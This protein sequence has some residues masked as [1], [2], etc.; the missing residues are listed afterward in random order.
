MSR[1]GLLLVV[2]LALSACNY[3]H[4][5]DASAGASGR[6]GGVSSM[7][8]VSLNYRTMQAAVLGPQCLRCHSAAGGNQGGLS[9]ET[10]Q[11]VRASLNR[12]YYRSIEKKDMPSGGLGA[13]QYDMLKSWIEAGAPETG[14][15]VSR[16]ISGPVGWSVVKNQIFKNSCLDCHSGASA[17]AELDLTS[18]EVVRRNITGIFKAAIIDQSMPLQPYAALSDSEKQALMKWISQGM[19]E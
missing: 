14:G 16:T 19:P 1:F 2:G 18:L 9:L 5:K 15:T 8:N 7:A 12:I 13:A 11:Q 3:N 4:V 17:E 6:P 10:Y